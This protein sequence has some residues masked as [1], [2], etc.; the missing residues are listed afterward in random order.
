MAIIGHYLKK[1]TGIPYIFDMRS[2]YPEERVDGGLWP[3]NNLIFK[4]IFLYFKSL[5]KVTLDTADHIVVLTEKANLI[6]NAYNKKITVIPCCADFSFFDYNKIKADHVKQAKKT[7]NIAPNSFVLSYLGSLGTWYLLD[8]MLDFFKVLKNTVPNSV[9]LFISPTD[10]KLILDKAVKLGID[11]NDIVVQFVP[12]KDLPV[13]LSVSSASIFF[14][15]NSYSKKASSPTKHAELMSLGIP[16]IANSGIG[17]ID[18]IIINTGSGKVIN[19]DSERPY[20]EACNQIK[21]LVELD[22]NT[23]RNHGINLFSLDKGILLYKEIYK[24]L[25]ALS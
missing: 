23:I 25:E 1:K 7:L 2:F 10:S 21:E 15:K 12:R 18:E 19:L 8:E 4:L 17:D 3:Q 13:I 11:I 14:I 22:K 9:F 6:L 5:E 16:V 20:Y 24:K